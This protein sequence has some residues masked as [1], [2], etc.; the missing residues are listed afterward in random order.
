[1]TS[2]APFDRSRQD[3]GASP[4]QRRAPM[5]SHPVR[6]AFTLIE[7]LCVIAIIALLI[8]ILT[9]ALGRSRDEAKKAAIQAQLQ[10]VATGCEM[11]LNDEAKYPVSNAAELIDP[12]GN[13]NW[14]IFGS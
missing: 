13:R 14:E 7:L 6:L 2:R 5:K 1:Q 3:P 11:F 8:G 12:T 10:A 9:P 4:S